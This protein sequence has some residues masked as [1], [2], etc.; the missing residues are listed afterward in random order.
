[1]RECSSRVLSNVLLYFSI[2]FAFLIQNEKFFFKIRGK[3]AKNK[4]IQNIKKLKKVYYLIAVSYY[5][6]GFISLH[7][8]NDSNYF[9][10]NIELFQKQC[11]FEKNVSNKS[12]RIWRGSS[13]KLFRF[14]IQS[15]FWVQLGPRLIFSMEIPVLLQIRFLVHQTLW[16]SR[17][18][19]SNVIFRLITLVFLYHFCN[20]THFL[21]GI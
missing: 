9:N 11:I 3:N 14:W 5:H 13:D 4:Q 7:N 21:V 20:I 1:L 16:P 6:R 10:I 12:C 19:I 15:S 17:I 18:S 2:F 8:I